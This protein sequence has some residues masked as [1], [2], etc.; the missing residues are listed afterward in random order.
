F[1]RCLCSTHN[2]IMCCSDERI[3]QHAPFCSLDSSR[4]DSIDT[5]VIESSYDPITSWKLNIVQHLL[6]SRS[7]KEIWNRPV[8]ILIVQPVNHVRRRGRIFLKNAP[9]D[10]MD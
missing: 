3:A 10:S 8:D 7:S 2:I 9:D 6:G 1:N 5:S 4:V